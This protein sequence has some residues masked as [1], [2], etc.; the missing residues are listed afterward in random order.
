MNA[1]LQNLVLLALAASPAL[2]RPAQETRAKKSLSLEGARSVAASA[3]AYAKEKGAGGAFAVVDDG[4]N[5]LTFARIDGTF[6]AGAKVSIGKART[7]ALFQ[8][9]TSFFE[10]VI[11][12]KGRVS[13]AALSMFEDF[14]P[15][16]GGVP[17]LVDGQIVGAIGVSGAMSAQQDDEIA[18]HAAEA[19]QSGATRSAKAFDVTHIKKE[20]V[21]SAFQKGAPLLENDAFKVHASRR[22]GPGVPEVHAKDTDIVYVLTGTASLVTGGQVVGGKEIGPN[23]IRGESIEG[24]ETRKLVP[25]DVVVVPAGAPHWFQEVETPFTYYVVKATR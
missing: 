20:A 25:G 24:G 8:K 7:A 6:P 4:G 1:M 22:D 2:A 5:L 16:Q 17:I 12:E 14:T 23:E 9:P 13:M 15:L 19:F 21:A 10:S 3:E 11:V 18:R